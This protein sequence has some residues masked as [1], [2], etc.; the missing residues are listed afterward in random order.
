MGLCHAVACGVV[1]RGNRPAWGEPERARRLALAE[2]IAGSDATTLILGETGT[3][4]EGLARFIHASSPR[5]DRP[6]VAV[7]C[8]ALP[9]TM[10]EAMLFGHQQ[11]KNG[12]ASCRERVCQYV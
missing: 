3:G 10:L 8:A 2:R 4:K 11:G 9:D 5:A 12:R 6:F 1:G 7:N